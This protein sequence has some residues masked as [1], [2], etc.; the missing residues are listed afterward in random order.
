MSQ[1]LGLFDFLNDISFNKKKIFSE[2]SERE[3]NSYMINRW[4]SM[5]VDTIMYAQEM[6]INSHL[7]KNMQYDYYFHSLKK[8]KRKFDYI[9]HKKQDEIDIIK[10]Y[11]GFSEARAKE[12]LNLFSDDDIEYMKSKLFKGG[13]SK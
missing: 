8:Q 1:K 6:N 7:P 10:E 13:V 2:D 9:K 12:M 11:Y 4:L 3:Y 5:R